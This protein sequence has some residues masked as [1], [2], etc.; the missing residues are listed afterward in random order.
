MTAEAVGGVVG[1]AVVGGGTAGLRLAAAASG[2]GAVEAT[3][4]AAASGAA[5]ACVG[6]RGVARRG[7]GLGEREMVV[8]VVG[9]ESEM[10]LDLADPV[11]IV[12][13]KEGVVGDVGVSP[14]RAPER[15]RRTD[16]TKVES[17]AT[18]GVG[19]FLTEREVACVRFFAM[20]S[21]SVGPA[22]LVLLVL[23][24]FS[25]SSFLVV[26]LVRSRSSGLF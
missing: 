15:R 20:L 5:A 14:C 3:A 13:P 24:L 23:L 7:A 26:V 16:F 18:V 22:G 6:V 1:A 8:G 17:K 9:V 11:P 10:A 25:S 19:A 2:K 21:L 12:P 4:A